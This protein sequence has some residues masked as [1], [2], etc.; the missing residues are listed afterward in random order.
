MFSILDSRQR[1]LFFVISLAARLPLSMVPVVV[2]LGA[3]N[4][5]ASIGQ[6][7]IV[8]GAVALGAG[9]AG[10]V[11]GP[12]W[13]RINNARLYALL[14]LLTAGALLVFALL[15]LDSW[16]VIAVGA[17]YGLL[18][19][20]T[21]TVVRNAWIE[22]FA[23]DEQGSTKSVA[24][25]VTF[26]P[27]LGVIGPLLSGG[28]FAIAGYQ[29]SLMLIAGIGL[30][31][32]LALSIELGKM[33][34]KNKKIPGSL[35]S[36]ARRL[37]LHSPLTTIFFLS[38][39][40]SAAQGA[41]IVLLGAQ[42]EVINRPDWLGA[43]LAINTIGVF[44]GSALFRRLALRP[45]SALHLLLLGEVFGILLYAF[46]FTL[47]AVYLWILIPA[48]ALFIAPMS[49]TLYLMAEARATE[50][51][52]SA[53]F[54]LLATTQFVGASAGQ[55]IFAQLA[56]I[57][58]PAKAT[59]IAAALLGAA[60]LLWA[61]LPY[62]MKRYRPKK[63][64]AWWPEDLVERLEKIAELDRG[65]AEEEYQNIL[66][67]SQEALKSGEV[68]P[69]PRALRKQDSEVDFSVIA[70]SR[71]AWTSAWD[72]SGQLSSISSALRC[73][74]WYADN[75]LP[76]SA[77][78]LLAIH[79]G[80]KYRH[81]ALPPDVLL[82]EMW[83]QATPEAQRFAAL[84]LAAILRSGR[85]YRSAESWLQRP[86]VSPFINEPIFQALLLLCQWAQNKNLDDRQRF[87]Q[88]WAQL[89]IDERPLL[90]DALHLSMNNRPQRASWLLSACQKYISEKRRY[91][92]WGVI[93]FFQARAYR[94]LGQGAEAHQ[95][96]LQAYERLPFYDRSG[97]NS[98]FISQFDLENELI[99]MLGDQP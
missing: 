1:W 15:P 45:G 72:S 35:L 81:Y 24:L 85:R 64:L 70:L 4:G 84:H 76:P 27:A 25:D 14:S 16:L 54:S 69:L 17:V 87:N 33:G 37:L 48:G 71:M 65:A 5:R 75:N 56:E 88:L 53:S 50:E 62:G 2:L 38:F 7:G 34:L 47:P 57:Y 90:L 91:P 29:H 26:V 6:A 31:F 63:A 40:V 60:L 12:A 3:L 82:P 61:V 10:L 32:G 19:P 9:V 66:N 20:Q 11:Q 79:F 98:W 18:R 23:A 59:L 83:Q 39:I 44:L 21:S 67:Y 77:A 92:G 95:H 52:R 96:L 8:V 46:I 68:P 89:D 42:L 99:E 36:S 93:D 28:L 55:A 22:Q 73:G 74:Q 86:E 97:T 49:T 41:F 51:D 43:L 94:A 78:R 58:T 80:F 13:D 30:I